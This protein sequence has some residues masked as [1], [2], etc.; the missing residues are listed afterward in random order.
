MYQKTFYVYILTNVLK[1]V[2]Y[3]GVTNDLQ[4]R[5]LEHYQNRGQQHSFCGRYHVNWLLYF[6]GHRYINNAIA[7]ENEIK[8]WRREKKMKLIGEMNPEL[9]FLNE[10]VFGKWPPDSLTGRV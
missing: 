3:T 6:E 8:G 5:I 2:V 1:T 10:D 4:Q 7:R 9:R